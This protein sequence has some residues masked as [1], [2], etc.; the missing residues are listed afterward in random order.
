M[1]VCRNWHHN[2]QYSAYTYYSLVMLTFATPIEGLTCTSNLC[3]RIND[4]LDFTSDEAGRF[5]DIF[6]FV[7]KFLFDLQA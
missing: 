3:E 6:L 7:T 1:P 5:A 2:K 4:L